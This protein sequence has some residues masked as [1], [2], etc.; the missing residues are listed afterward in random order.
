MYNIVMQINNSNIINDTDPRIRMKSKKAW[1]KKKNPVF[2]MIL[3]GIMNVAW[4]LLKNLL[5]L[6]ER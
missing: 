6:L 2:V 1:K 4:N 5:L 3:A